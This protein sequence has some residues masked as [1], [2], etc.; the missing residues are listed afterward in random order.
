MWLIWFLLFGFWDFCGLCVTWWIFLLFYKD[1]KVKQIVYLW[2]TH[3]A[4][5]I[6]YSNLL[7]FDIQTF[8]L[9]NLILG[10][11]KPFHYAYDLVE[12][13]FYFTSWQAILFIWK[14]FILFILL[15]VSCLEF[16]FVW[17]EHTLYCFVSFCLDYLC[18]TFHANLCYFVISEYFVTDW[19]I[20]GFVCTTV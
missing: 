16:Y 14:K 15:N 18:Q 2:A 20:A 12:V 17:Y 1:L 6:W 19:S 10:Y 7:K 5:Y 4:C 9:L 8:S 3:E 13:L 11:D